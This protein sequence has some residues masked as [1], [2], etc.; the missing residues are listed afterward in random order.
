MSNFEE[1]SDFSS[2]VVGEYACLEIWGNLLGDGGGL[3]GGEVVGGGVGDHQGVV[4]EEVGWGEVELEPGSFGLGV[5]G[6]AE[7]GIGADAA[8][9]SEGAT[10]G[11]A[12]GF[13]KFGGENIDHGGL[14]GRAKVG[15]IGLGGRAVFFEEGADRGF[16]AAEAE[17]EITRVDHAA[18]K[19]KAGGVTIDS[20]AVDEDA[21]G[22]AE[23][24]KLGSFVKRL[25]GSV[26][27]GAAKEL[28]FS[29][30]FDIQKQSVPSADD[31]CGV[32]WNGVTPEEGGEQVALHMVY[33]EEI[34]GG[35]EG[36]AFG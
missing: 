9:D 12:R 11:L 28:V 1:N 26:V 15:E 19:I 16:E 33:G 31:E 2:L 20:K 35:S 5:E 24:E 29:E 36:K 3:A 7:G 4:G 25:T 18:R 21:A 14:K 13:Q 34:F 23:A 22:I 30:T 27:E 6:M 8:A 32:G 17:I 10:A